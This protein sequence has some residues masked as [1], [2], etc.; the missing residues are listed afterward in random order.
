MA[1]VKP[2][3]SFAEL[4][5][6]FWYDPETGFLHHKHAKPGVFKDA[7]AG[8]VSKRGYVQLG[9]GDTRYQAHRVIWCMQTGEDPKHLAVDHRNGIK[10]DNRFENLRLATT[11]QN[12]WNV[13]GRCI[14]R[15]PSG[16]YCA[17]IRH[18]GKLL[19]LGTFP[20]FE[21][22]AAAYDA[23]ALELRGEFACTHDSHRAS[24]RDES[25]AGDM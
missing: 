25:F 22:A 16:N 10:S 8:N 11:Q 3:P 13:P 15:Y 12:N 2:L 9:I 7:F 20:T 14:E 1:N 23:K 21:E 18:N 5:Q 24:N 4:H 17:R 19:T 6:R